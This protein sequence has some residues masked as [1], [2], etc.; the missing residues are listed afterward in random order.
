MIKPELGNLIRNFF[1]HYLVSQ[2][3][4]SGH[5]VLA[6]RD[7]WKLFLQFVSRRLR[8]CCAGLAVENLTAETV[9][10]FL[11]YLERDRRNTVPTRNNRLAA[12][13]SFF[14]YLAE[15]EPRCLAQAE[16]I[17]SVPFK[18]HAQHV[19]EYLEHEEV[20]KIFSEID[21]RTPLGQRDDALLRVLYNTG[22]RAQELVNMDV[23][24]VRFSRPWHVRILGKG[25]KERT[26]P[27]WTETVRAIKTYLAA[28]S[29]GFDEST[30]LFINRDGDRLSRFGLRHIIT[31]RVAQ[32]AKVCPSLFKRKVT[33]HTWRH[34]TAM[35]LLQS[36][37]DL[38]MIRSW[39]G[40][41]SIETT[42]GYVEIDLE[43]K[44]K[45]LQSAEKLIPAKRNAGLSWKKSPDILAW[46]SGL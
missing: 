26:C 3:G 8:K 14:H 23:T 39:L 45:T 21:C 37:V 46:L 6:Y 43:M 7:T 27:L 44:R 40:H 42:H 30:P 34:T 38:N 20:L 11:E 28:R 32:A 10:R 36:N 35:H 33:P 15:M 4:L 12:I 9:R 41:A 1:D 2:R 13:H 29:V 25:K 19:P 24:H 5:T 22:M 18:R 16:S 31:H 17:L